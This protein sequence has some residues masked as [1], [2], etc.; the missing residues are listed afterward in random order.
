MRANRERT[1]WGLDFDE[2]TTDEVKALVGKD[3]I[4][5]LGATSGNETEA[6]QLATLILDDT[7]NEHL[8]AR[9]TML[10][11]KD[12][13]GTGIDPS[14]PDVYTSKIFENNFNE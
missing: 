5:D 7:A 3:N 13:F 11:Q 12:A 14:C 4:L 9:Q 2:D 10:R 1:Y 8:N 6:I